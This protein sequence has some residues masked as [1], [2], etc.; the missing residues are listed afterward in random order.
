MARSGCVASPARVDEAVEGAKPK[1]AAGRRLCLWV[2]PL[3]TLGF[4][5][6]SVPKV[7]PV[8]TRLSRARPGAA[9]GR[10]L[11]LRVQQSRSSTK[12]SEVMQPHLAGRSTRWP[13]QDSTR[14][15]G[16]SCCSPN[17]HRGEGDIL[18][19]ALQDP[20][21]L[22]ALQETNGAFST[23]EIPTALQLSRKRESPRW[24]QTLAVCSIRE[25]S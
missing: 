2:Q 18:D 24:P 20:L 12:M 21:V 6:R 19:L 9:A 16:N 4:Q 25:C 10:R 1:A 22:P 11:C 23:S 3:S 7:Q 8:S 13:P 15:W 14:C 17:S 5:P